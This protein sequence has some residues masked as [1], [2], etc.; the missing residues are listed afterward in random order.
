MNRTVLACESYKEATFVYEGF[1]S[2][3]ELTDAE[4]DKKKL[5]K[6]YKAIKIIWND[7]IQKWK[8]AIREAIII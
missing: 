1:L 6:T 2:D 4:S 8:A 3:A 5:Q 7:D